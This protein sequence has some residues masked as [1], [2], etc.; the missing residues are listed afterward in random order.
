MK[1]FC[2]ATLSNLADSDIQKQ[3]TFFIFLSEYVVTY[4]KTDKIS[5][6]TN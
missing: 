3:S 2:D 1:V 5:I 6:C 4:Q